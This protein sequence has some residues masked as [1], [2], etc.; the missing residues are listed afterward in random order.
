MK[1]SL[2]HPLFLSVALLFGGTSAIAAEMPNQ[3]VVLKV[4]G[5]VTAISPGES[6]PRAVRLGDKLPQGT[7]ITTGAA[8]SVQ[9]QP[10]PGSVSEITENASV[11]LDKL[12]IDQNTAGVTTK[13]TARLNLKSGSVVSNLDPTKKSIND[14]G[15]STPKGVAAARGTVFSTTVNATGTNVQSLQGTVTFTLATGVVISIDIGTGAVMRTD[16]GSTVPVPVSLAELAATNSAVAAE[17]KAAVASATDI[18]T[19]KD[20]LGLSADTTTAM[21]AAVIKAASLA[22]PAE[23]TK[24]VSDAI[25]AVQAGNANELNTTDN[26]DAAIKAIIGAGAAAVPPEDRPAFINAI[27]QAQPDVSGTTIDTSANP[28]TPPPIDTDF[29]SQNNQDTSPTSTVTVQ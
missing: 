18:L 29:P 14:Y 25:D 8:S 21:L 3:A 6:Q 27:K 1:K 11:G 9:I 15:V 7:T 17:I 12:T 20:A 22:L 13:Q 16:A 5:T 23:A 2:L 19:T 10:F 26:K 28:S 4:T 24:F